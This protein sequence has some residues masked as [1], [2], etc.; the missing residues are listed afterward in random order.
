MKTT[1]YILAAL[2]LCVFA[3]CTSE[4]A[5]SGSSIVY[6][7]TA[8]IAPDGPQTRTILIDNPGVRVESF[9]TFG[10]AI[11]LF[12]SSG[13]NLTLF[14]DY[15]NIG[16]GGKTAL[17][18]SYEGFPSGN[19]SALYPADKN[20]KVSGGKISTVFPDTQHYVMYLSQPEPDPAV[21]L[22]AGTGNATS[23]V[24]FKNIMAVLKIGR[25]FDRETTVSAVTFSDLSGGAVSGTLSIDPSNNYASQVSGGNAV[26]T[27]DCGEGVE[28]EPGAT[29]VFYM[30]VPAKAYP[31][32]IRLSFITSE[33]DPVTVDVGTDNGITLGRG[34]IYP[35]GEI[36]ARDYIAG[37][38]AS[39]LA[40]NAHLMNSEVMRKVTV[41]D[42]RMEYV[43]NA[44]GDYVCYGNER[45]DAPYYS[46]LI[47]NEMAFKEGDYLVF[48]ATDDLPNG[49]VFL[50]TKKETPYADENHS[51]IEAHLTT[52]FAK[53]F[54]KLDYGAQLFDA[55]GNRIED[56]GE[57]ID[58]ASYLSD[59]V[60]YQGESIPYSITNDGQILISEEDFE[61]AVTK[62]TVIKTNK[63]ISSPKLSMTISDPKKICEAT[64]GAKLTI[65]MRAGVKVE[66]GELQWLHF[67]FNP[68]IKVSGNFSIKGPISKSKEF[69]LITLHFVP[70]IPVA[71]GVVLTPELEI[72]GSVGVGGEVVFSTSIE[73][74]Y[75]LG[76][77]GF[78]YTCQQGFN[79][80]HFESEPKPDDKFQPELG[81]SLTGTL[82][83]QGTLSAIPS[84]S[85]FGIFRA[86]IY[87][88]FTLKFAAT[89]GGETID[90][91]IYDTRKLSLV[92]EL[93]FSPYVASLGGVF[94]SKWEN[95]IPKIE[96]D[97][98][99]E[100]YLDPVMDY[101][102]KIDMF[103][104]SVD[105]IPF[106]ATKGGSCYLM[107]LKTQDYVGTLFAIGRIWRSLDGFTYTCKS[108]KPTL[109]DWEV[110][111][112]VMNGEFS[113]RWQSYLVGYNLN[114]TSLIPPTP[115]LFEQNRYQL[116][117]I[118]SNQGEDDDISASGEIFCPGEF[119]P[120]E[121]RVLRLVCVNKRN[122][123]IYPLK[124]S[125]P[126]TY[127]WPQT[128]DG[129][130][131][132]V[133][134]IS[135][136]EYQNYREY[137]FH[138]W[139]SDIPLPF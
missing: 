121:P 80:H 66:D 115:E 112:L 91:N 101:N 59:V 13:E 17:F 38:D 123:M 134:S 72:R 28:M 95:L 56:A 31:K 11:S 110:C 114:L 52:D 81:A 45:V 7:L 86:G 27:L 104:P 63:S 118:P 14:V 50:I 36:S 68:Q 138:V 46:I 58:L 98:L 57:D 120:G 8:S 65:N 32:G 29:G 15:E 131:W 92:P 111:V 87:T 67:T 108:L 132:D 3:A 6:E 19:L 124:Q 119:L 23:G 127:Y 109:D 41:L 42:V 89:I 78:S 103:G 82:Y 12:T 93:A 105:E 62:S 20:A 70:G 99:W 117:D 33:G 49:G 129:P 83:A 34:I 79:F 139:P 39:I 130:W 55:D 77:F 30:V 75:D 16:D 2:L 88:D 76:N 40:D 51:R 9:W 26:L 47:P 135:S 74:A 71:P 1:R 133:K 137:G 37:D 102:T 126:I 96:F 69:H 128:P 73:Y 85:L 25:S 97:P 4:P 21:S 60:D 18:H 84:L 64:V 107:Q 94:S 5:P 106:I 54:K 125:Y 100:R 22:M 122:N 53:A 116:M 90:N 24:A 44:D 136:D 10:D 43:I 48:E 113:S 35:V 61:E